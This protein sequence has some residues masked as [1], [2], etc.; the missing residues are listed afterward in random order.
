MKEFSAYFESFNNSLEE[1]VKK[2]PSKG[3]YSPIN[4]LLNLGENV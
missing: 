2:N 3:L 1:F 4:Y